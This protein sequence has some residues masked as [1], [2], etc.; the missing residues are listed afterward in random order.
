MSIAC[1]YR[2]LFRLSLTIST[3][4]FRHWYYDKVWAL[5]ALRNVPE[6]L[7]VNITNAICLLKFKNIKHFATPSVV[8]NK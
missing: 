7:R 4:F 5:S 6:V 1:R 2:H 3:P 8:K